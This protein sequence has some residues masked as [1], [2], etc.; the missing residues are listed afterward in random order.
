MSKKRSEKVLPKRSTR[1]KFEVPIDPEVEAWSKKLFHPIK[2]IIAGLKENAIPK[3]E[4]DNLSD[5]DNFSASNSNFVSVFPTVSEFKSDPDTI[6]EPVSLP[7]PNNRGDLHHF[8]ADLI[9]LDRSRITTS[10]PST[11]LDRRSDLD[12][13][14]DTDKLSFQSEIQSEPDK[15]SEDDKISASLRVSFVKGELRIPNYVLKGLLP[16][17]TNSEFVVYFYLYFLSYG[18]NKTNCYVSAG[19]LAQSV[20]LTD[21]T[22]FRTLNS[23]EARGLIKRTDRHFLGKA[24]GLTFDVFLPDTDNNS[25]TDKFSE[26]KPEKQVTEMSDPDK[27]SDMKD[28]DHDRKN[29]LDHENR[30]IAI[31][32][33]LTNNAWTPS[34]HMQYLQIKMIPIE[35]IERN[36]KLIAARAAEPVRSFAYFAKS[37]KIA[38]NQK[39][40][41][42]KLQ[43]FIKEIK[44]LHIGGRLTISDLEDEVR[45]KCEINGIVFD[46]TLFNELVTKS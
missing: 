7:P 21:R 30:T 11:P 28:H 41:K 19:K 9:D 45:A 34:D 18:F 20:N 40:I 24:G 1:K 38:S 36:M 15:I 27:K 33:D 3:P 13:I 14:S 4:A 35:M 8:S 43:E 39:S 31:Y 22:V 16:I 25:G 29:R 46:K 23:L 10:T 37:L 12:K 32:Q 17:L 6:S 5:T 44:M 42:Q 26:R 2:P